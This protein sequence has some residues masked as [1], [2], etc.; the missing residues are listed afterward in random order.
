MTT[1]VADRQKTIQQAVSA[2]NT[3]NSKRARELFEQAVQ[4]ADADPSTW[5]GLAFAC[6]RLGDDAATLAAVDKVLEIDPENIR[7]NIFKGDHLEQRGKSRAALQYY[8]I[9]LQIAS[10]ATEFPDDV[11]QG[12]QRAQAFCQRLDGEYHD[13]LL[14]HLEK[15]GYDP[16]TSRGRFQQSLDILIGKSEVYYQRPRRY[17]FPG[18]PQRQFY[19]REE[20]SWVSTIESATDDIRDELRKVMSVSSSF[21]PYL[22]SDGEHL[23]PRGTYLVNNVDWGAFYLWHYGELKAE[24]TELCPRA[25]AA[26]EA[27]QQPQIPGQAPIAL[28][29]KLR[30]RTRIPPHHGMINTRL[31]CHLP[32][33]V[34]ED[35]GALRVGSEQRPWVEGEM[36]IFDDSMEH[37]AWNDSDE[38]RVVLLFEI[39]R[40][41]L[42]AEERALVAS[43]L[44]AVRSYFDD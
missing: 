36:L 17:Y 34:P 13:Y 5:L 4:H 16:Q 10:R 9:A 32:L 35:C 26:L 18:L 20:F 39:W 1:T 2:L 30:P 25:I 27:A 40:P 11:R 19:E 6:A 37:E 15:D 23:N 12:L 8:H 42:S 24:A 14:R 31:I 29:S 28:F 3:G 43:V 22:E 44:T 7:G 41:E 33:I 38:E 21:K